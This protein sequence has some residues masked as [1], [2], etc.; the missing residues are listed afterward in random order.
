MSEETNAPGPQAGAEQ[1]SETF[2]ADYVAKLR[3]EAAKYRTEAKANADAAKRL[4]EYEEASKTAEQRAEQRIAEL[5]RKY[6]DSETARLRSDIAARHGIDA[7]DR[8]LFLTGADEETLNA[9]A[10]RLA[11]RE[12]ERKKRGNV[13]PKEGGAADTPNAEGSDLRGYT[14]R[15]FESARADG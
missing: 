11:E 7:T 4:A 13:A 6:A 5:E 12:A 1:E 2:D 14:R 9:Q 10:Q 3:K 8:D 15:L